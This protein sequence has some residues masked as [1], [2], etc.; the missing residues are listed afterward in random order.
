MATIR[1]WHFRLHQW[2]HDDLLPKGGATACAIIEGDA[3]RLGVAVCSLKDVYCRAKG[4]EEAYG[5]AQAVPDVT[6]L[7]MPA[8]HVLAGL[9]RILA[10]ERSASIHRGRGGELR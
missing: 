3:V 2:I 8:P 6:L 7:G 10:S 5:Q 1:Y 4:R 9:A